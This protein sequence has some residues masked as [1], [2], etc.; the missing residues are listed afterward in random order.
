MSCSRCDTL[1]WNATHQIF[2]E[3]TVAR[4]RAGNK[5]QHLYSEDFLHTSGLAALKGPYFGLEV[6]RGG[7]PIIQ[8][9]N[10]IE[11]PTMSGIHISIISAEI[12]KLNLP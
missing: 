4:P 2:A 8:E 10:Q 11:T 6:E 3:R 5:F 7:L 9:L 12:S 1:L